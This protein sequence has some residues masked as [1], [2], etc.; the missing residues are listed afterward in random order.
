MTSAKDNKK[1]RLIIV[2][3][4]T[5]AKTISKF[6]KKGYIV[7]SSYGHI[8]DLPKSK[9]G[10]DVDDD[11]KLT[12]I[13]PTKSKKIVTA[14]KKLSE[15]S[16][17]VILATD[18]DR[19]GEAIAWH[20]TQA[21]KLDPEKT[22]RIAFHEI[23]S[24]AI[25]AALEH[26]RHIDMNLVNAQQGRR[27]LDRLVGYKLSPFLWKKV[28]RGLSAGRVQSVAMRLIVEREEEITTFKPEE[29]WS[30]EALFKKESGETIEASLAKINDASLDKFDLKNKESVDAVLEKLNKE[31]FAISHIEKKEVRKN[32]LP[33]FI[34]S[35]L[36]Q[37][38]AKR[39]GYSSKKTMLLAQ[40]LYEQGLITYMRTD[41]VNLAKEALSAVKDFI[42]KEYGK[43]YSE[44]TPRVFQ[45]KSRLAQE[46][47]EAIR[48]TDVFKNPAEFSGD[49]GEK[50][51]YT[52]IWSRFVG[53]QMPQARFDA[54]HIDIQGGNY[55]FSANGSILTFDGFL[56]VWKQKFVE[57]ELPQVTEKESLSVEQFTPG[58]HFTEPPARYS[59]ATLIKALEEHGIGRP[60]TYAP[61]I[62]TIQYRNYVEKRER[63][64]F[65]TE[66]GTLVTN[67][68]K[69][70]FPNIIDINF[71]ATVENELDEIADGK[72]TW[73]DVIT[74]FYTP[75]AEDLKK[76]YEEVLKQDV[77]H[78][79]TTEV[80]EKCGKPMVVKFSRFGK[81]LGCSG[82]PE[83]KNTKKLAKDEP[84]KIGLKCLKCIDGDVIE[85]RV[86]RGRA[87]GK[88][89]W[90]CSR[91]PD[92][93]YASWTNPL[94]KEGEVAPIPETE[95][96]P[97]ETESEKEEV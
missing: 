37:E 78:E 63:R 83:C 86:T 33:P 59:E 27:V 82:F 85:R 23:T 96:T 88:I 9:L 3:S 69:E 10:I 48:P 19:E 75:F 2:E 94:K 26:P 72:E 35:T 36:Q 34:T 73:R 24:A 14:L 55:T 21:L 31:S 61:T 7:E 93:D 91:Y 87:R 16:D 17:G 90:G 32:P 51:L 30:L 22:D 46:A 25:N 12:Y 28:A 40:R 84:K 1:M 68:L 70:H 39:L 42:E 66:I 13:I 47:H 58:Q 15:K 67:L 54:T 64:F 60:S 5:K 52:L 41:S 95:K 45:T 38:A 57:K 77:V 20:L 97:E 53:S 79:A 74:K 4:P 29:Y 92:C 49:A 44:D 71:T 50:K 56:K 11:F 43:N 81:F 6:L 18:E 65:P 80:C 89:F 8:R 76:K 62:S